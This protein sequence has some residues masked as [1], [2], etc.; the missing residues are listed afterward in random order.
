MIAS[1]TQQAA[2]RARV[3]AVLVGLWA[4]IGSEAIFF[5]SLIASYLYLR[6]R[7]GEWPP[8]GVPQLE[9]ILPLFNTVV[10]L[11]SGVTMHGAHMSARSGD[12]D[13]LRQGTLAT[14]LLGAAFLCGQAYE[15]ATAGFGLGSGLLGSTFFTLTGFHG[16]HVLVGLIGLTLLYSRARRGHYQAGLE[17]PS[18]EGVTLYWHFVDAV[19][20]VLLTLL[21]LI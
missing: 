5:G 19:W 1:A 6:I 12:V 9:I 11:S 21:Y 10:L 17:Y 15:Y 7:A 14:I 16:A 8:A 20:V 18:I 13:G 3:N 2:A 4:F